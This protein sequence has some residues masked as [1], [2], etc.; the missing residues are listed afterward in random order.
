MLRVCAQRKLESPQ[1]LADA[2]GRGLGRGAWLCASRACIEK[3]WGRKSIQR[4]LKGAAPGEELKQQLL[5]ACV[6]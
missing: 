5:Q 4:A 3:A 1:V 6:E 2:D